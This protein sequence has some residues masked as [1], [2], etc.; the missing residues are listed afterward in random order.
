MSISIAGLVGAALGG[1]LGWIDSKILKGVLQ[2]VEE[3]NKR[4]GGDGGFVARYRTVL[5][6]LSFAVPIIGFPI[7]GYL[8]GSQLAG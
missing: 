2:A 6:G 8:A 3:K 1:Y 5:R 4:M 7:I